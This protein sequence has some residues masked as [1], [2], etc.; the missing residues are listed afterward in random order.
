VV[1]GAFE[2]AAADRLAQIYAPFDAPVVCVDPTTAEFTKYASN[3][4]LATLISFANEAAMAGERIGGVQVQEAFR[5]LALDRRWRGDPAGMA[6]YAWPGCGFGGYCLPKDVA[7]LAAAAEAHGA[8]M[9]LL[10]AVLDV[11]RRAAQHLVAKVA[12]VAPPGGKVAVLGLAFKPGSEDVRGTPAL[13]VIEGLRKRGFEV[14]AYDPRAM[15]AFGRAHPGLVDLAHSLEAAVTAAEAI[16]LTT[17][18]PEFRSVRVLAG[19]KPLIDGRHFL[20][21]SS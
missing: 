19:P 3:A 20:G 17:A 15:G 2:A 18:W 8:R 12:A 13:P 7:A 16:V 9:P 10:R 11:N 14:L 4:L 6:S 21:G 1:I 5:A